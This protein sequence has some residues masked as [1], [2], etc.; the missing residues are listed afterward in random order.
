MGT[1]T[2]T[3]TGAGGS[4]DTGASKTYTLTVGAPINV[5]PVPIDDPRWLL[6][7]AVLM[8]LSAAMVMRVRA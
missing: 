3:M 8:A 1:I 6:L 5:A 2:V 4:C 7:A